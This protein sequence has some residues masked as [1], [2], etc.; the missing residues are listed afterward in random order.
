MGLF[1]RIFSRLRKKETTTTTVLSPTKV[2]SVKITDFTSGDSVK[3]VTSTSP[4]GGTTTTRTVRSSGGGS[5]SPVQQK[6]L[7]Q[8]TKKLEATGKSIVLLPPKRRVRI[9]RPVPRVVPVRRPPEKITIKKLPP[10]PLVTRRKITFGNPLAFGRNYNKATGAEAFTIAIPIRRQE[11]KILVRD[12]N[13]RFKDGKLV[14]VKPTGRVLITEERFLDAD[15]RRRD[16]TPGFTFGDTRL[17]KPVI[18]KPVT[19]VFEKFEELPQV[20][21]SKLEKQLQDVRNKISEIEVQKLRAKPK[22]RLKLDK[23]LKLAGL[24]LEK[25]SGEFVLGIVT[26]PSS[27]KRIIQ[28]PKILQ[29]IPAEI[30][31]EAVG[32]GQILRTSPGRAIAR[33]GGEILI[34][35]GTGTAL[36]II[37]RLS[38]RLAARL[39]PK[40]RGVKRTVI[41]IPSGQGGKKIIDIKIG[42]TVKKIG[43]P[44]P[45]QAGLAGTRVIAVSAQADRLVNLLKT[46][47]VVRKPIPGEP[48]LKLITR[49]L[50]RKFDRGIIK[51]NELLTLNQRIRVETKG[52]GSLLERSFFA[53]PRGRLRP[54]RLG[55]EAEDASLLD[56]LFGD[57]TF[58]TQKPQ[59]LVFE[60]VKIQKFPKSLKDVEN[61]LKAG[62]TLTKEEANR[63]LQ[64]QLKKSGDFKPIGALTREPEI[65][66]AP[67]EIVKKLKTLA[68]TEI[69]GRIVPIVS[70]KVVKSKPSTRK[71]LNKVREGKISTKELKQL[72]KNLI[73][74]TGFKA[75]VSRSKKPLPRVAVKRKLIVGATRLIKPRKRVRKVP[76]TPRRKPRPIPT[77]R[78]IAPVRVARV[79]RAVRVARRVVPAKRARRVARLLRAPV[80]V[81]KVAKVPSV[82]KIKKKKVVKKKPRAFNVFAKPVKEKKLI[83][84]NKKPLS[85]AR[86]KDLGSRVVDTSLSRTFKIKPTGGKPKKGVLKAPSGNFARTKNKFRDFRIVKGKRVPLK[87][88]F[89]EKKGKALLDTR[90][91]KKGITL[92]RRIAMLENLAKARKAKQLKTKKPLR[93]KV[94]KKR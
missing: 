11:G 44:L 41:N 59:V 92:R 2:S 1:R 45:K 47:R 86:A 28:N 63:L 91:E 73:K 94:R 79:V 64:F 83:K 8:E 12:F 52:A 32:F 13:F 77:P 65:T 56:I 67:G 74:E 18:K 36:K 33:I 6:V 22:E 61:K 46:K 9:I 42:G 90:G 27:L 80:P 23:E 17:K 82:K 70:V 40:F 53:D 10:R 75:T 71:L 19:I 62:K 89:I 54:S 5:V 34:L 55:R 30:K 87:N 35:K 50:L 24:E 26:L 29:A 3:T 58:R 93:V 43:E 16:K 81:K 38:G 39:N 51:R 4:S 66:L 21:K 48:D 78:R 37:G 57:V 31:K 76:V 60:D 72:R 20:P 69:N 85:K 88:T 25:L 7:I 49:R 15:K 14:N 68:I 84:V